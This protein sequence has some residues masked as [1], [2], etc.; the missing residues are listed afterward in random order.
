MPIE[1]GVDMKCV[2]ME[3][4]GLWRTVCNNEFVINDGKPSDNKMKYCCFCGKI[5]EEFPEEE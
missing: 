4:D 3:K 2:W 5:I 1:A